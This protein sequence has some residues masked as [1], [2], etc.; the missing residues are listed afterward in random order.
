MEITTR[1]DMPIATLRFYSALMD[2]L[3]E[4]CRMQMSIQHLRNM[5][6]VICKTLGYYPTKPK[7]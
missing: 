2:H 4:A 1:S 7:A 3:S 6:D 5:V